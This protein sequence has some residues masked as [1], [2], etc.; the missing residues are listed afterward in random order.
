MQKLMKGPHRGDK[1]WA[2]KDDYLNAGG[3]APSHFG[4]L[5]LGIFWRIF[6]IQIQLF[7]Y[8]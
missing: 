5:V 7:L 6:H 4:E 8:M 2:I 1:L 3:I